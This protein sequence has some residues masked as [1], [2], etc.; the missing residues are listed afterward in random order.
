PTGF[1]AFNAD[2][3][4]YEGAGSNANDILY[5]SEGQDDIDG[6]E[7]DDLI[8]GEGGNDTLSGGAGDDI[9]SGGAGSDVLTGGDGAD[10]FVFTSLSETDNGDYDVITDF[11]ATDTLT[12]ESDNF[13]GLNALVGNLNDLITAGE[14]V[15][16]LTDLSATKEA[17]A[18][19]IFVQDDPASDKSALYYDADGSGSGYESTKVAEFDNSATLTAEDINLLNGS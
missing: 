18:T 7:G 14:D 19:F 3:F 15:S 5:G 11:T 16:F 2:S 6:L 12:F 9:L 8:K 4:I 13:E 10:S 17:K 1:K